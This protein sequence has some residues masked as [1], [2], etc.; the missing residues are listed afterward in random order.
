MENFE[1]EQTKNINYN[2]NEDAVPVT[3]DYV[4]KSMLDAWCDGIETLQDAKEVALKDYGKV[5]KVMNDGTNSEEYDNSGNPDYPTPFG[6]HKTFGEGAEFPPGGKILLA[7]NA[8]WG[9]LHLLVYNKEHNEWTDGMLEAHNGV[10]HWA[11]LGESDEELKEMS[12]AYLEYKKK[13]GDV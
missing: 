9:S 8:S 10:T 6:W 1:F 7:F 11:F 2:P 4:I 5:T 3:M 12:E 13:H